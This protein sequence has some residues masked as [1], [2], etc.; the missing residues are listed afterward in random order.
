[1]SF[2]SRDQQRASFEFLSIPSAKASVDART[3]LTWPIKM[4]WASKIA[5]LLCLLLLTGCSRFYTDYGESDGVQGNQSLNGFGALRTS[6]EETIAEVDAI[7]SDQP[8]Q[9]ETF[10]I[11]RLSARAK[12]FEAIV[13]LP[14]S[15][16][17]INEPAVTSWMDQWLREKDR[18][19]VFVVPDG[20][21][22]EAYYR[23]AADL[24][25]PDQ[26][27]EYR[28]RLAKQINERLLEDGRRR[29]VTITDWFRADALP[30]RVILPNRR[31]A[32]YDLRPAPSP[33]TDGSE[34]D[35]SDEIELVEMELVEMDEDELFEEIEALLDE[36]DSA[37]EKIPEEAS[38]ESPEEVVF[39][40]DRLKQESISIESKKRPLTTLA[41]VQHPHWNESQVLVVASGG[42]LTNFAM[43]EKPA[44]ELSQQI[45]SEIRRTAGTEEE[46]IEIAFLSSGR[47]PVPISTA[48]PGA[49]TA[50]GMELLTTWPLSLVTMHGI[51]LGVV[52]CLMLLPAFG[53][54]R[55]VTYNRNTH[56]GNHLSAMATLM[57]GGARGPDGPVFAKTKI[58]QYL[59][60]VRG[61][62][63]GPWVLPEADTD[64]VDKE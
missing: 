37:T 14:T 16:P 18:T 46:T 36:G 22:T 32:D 52:M 27:L 19:I 17:P 40:F 63:S 13:W 29:D 47:M 53:R 11:A 7:E 35:P 8:T 20:G 42:L 64:A 59:R 9:I 62:T 58:S 61:E 23:S 51:F 5:V 25:P 15:W 24:A 38:E 33:K 48:K 30:Y 60:V 1:M 2:R 56:F 43:T 57:R 50:T 54:A 34:S 55:K 6:F 44:I 12:R 39:S 31:I 41:R 4:T 45:Q 49:P 26:R 28:R 10:D 21:S 3:K